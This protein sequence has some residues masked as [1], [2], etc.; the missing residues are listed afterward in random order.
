MPFIV[1]ATDRP[2]SAELRA[3]VRPAHIAYLEANLDKLLAAGAKLADDGETATGSIYILATDSRAE[4][5]AFVAADPFVIEGVLGGIVARRW[6]KAIFD[7]QSFI[8]KS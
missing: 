6:R 4:A 2:N 1:E 3:R 8:P 5:E 7:H